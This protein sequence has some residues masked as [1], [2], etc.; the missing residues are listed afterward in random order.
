MIKV[1]GY[2]TLYI[3]CS[4]ALISFNKYLMHEGRFPFAVTLVLLHNLV[5]AGLACGLYIAKPSLF[6]SISDQHQKV[7]VDRNLFLYGVVPIALMFS[8]QLVLTN[9]AYLHSSIAFLQ[10]MKEGNLVLVYIL[11]LIAALETFS[12]RQVQ[13][14]LA[15]IFAT[16]LTIKGEL[17]FSPTAFTI[18]GIG[19]LFESGRIVMQMIVLTAAGRKLDALT[20]ML[21][22][23]PL[24]VL[25]LGVFV[26]GLWIYGPVSSIPMP[27][28]SDFMEW[29][30]LLV[31]NGLVAFSLNLAI[32]MFIKNS[33]A[34][35]FILAGI[36]KDGAIV[37]VGAFVLAEEVSR[38]Q[39]LG[40]GIQ[41]L[42]IVT[43][44][45]MKSFPDHFKDGVVK[46]MCSVMLEGG[47]PKPRLDPST[48]GK[49]AEPPRSFASAEKSYGTLE[50]ARTR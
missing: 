18:Q 41:L 31:M 25:I 34:V 49:V 11:S 32:A 45:A 14:L 20:Y 22:V 12:W 38:L 37:A 9:T 2:G 1:I 19:Q 24:C 30:P 26:S 40:F 42:G 44:S 48:K 8:C 39:L 23:T 7:P 43:W 6:P 17:H 4:T 29:W 5:G 47:G 46:G 13:V 27:A 21:F 15:V 28:T 33:S 16:S 35:S 50:E 3:F 36:F 10:M